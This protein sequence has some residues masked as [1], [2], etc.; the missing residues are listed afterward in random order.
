MRWSLSFAA[1]SSRWDIFPEAQVTELLNSGAD[2]SNFGRFLF[3]SHLLQV[4][5]YRDRKLTRRVSPFTQL[6]LK[7]LQSQHTID[8]GQVE[9][10]SA[11]R[12]WLSRILNTCS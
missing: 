4:L 12:V 8:R 11:L 1:K 3:I 5:Y 9:G 10:C 2:P 6:F 7:L